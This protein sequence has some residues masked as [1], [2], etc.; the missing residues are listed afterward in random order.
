MSAR[1]WI[2]LPQ[3][4]IGTVT[5][6]QLMLSMN[7]FRG[8]SHFRATDLWS[9]LL[10]LHGG[11]LRWIAALAI[12]SSPLA[13]QVVTAFVA[14][15]LSWSAFVVLFNESFRLPSRQQWIALV[16]SLLVTVLWEVN[17]RMVVDLPVG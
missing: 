12:R 7:R 9:F 5:W 4:G 11:F 6:V 14:A 1:V 17:N 3:V 15:T 13:F 16:M 10:M 8:C 2:L